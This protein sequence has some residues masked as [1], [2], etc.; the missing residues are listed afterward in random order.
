M[1]PKS[2]TLKG[3]YSYQKEQTI[4]F[5]PL[6]NGQLFGIFGSVGRGKCTIVEAITFAV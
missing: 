5:D 3:V 6:L 4:H 2:L 1:I